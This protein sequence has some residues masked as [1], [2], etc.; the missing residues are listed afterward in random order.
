MF[1][2]GTMLFLSSEVKS[3]TFTINVMNFAFSPANISVSVGDTIK[4][5]YVSG[6]HTTTNNGS[7][8]T[9]RPA[10]A[11][12]WDA[13]INVGMLQY[14][15][16][17]TVPGSYTYKC[18]FHSSMIGNF[19]ATSP[20]INLNLSSIIEGFW[21]GA[22][23][24]SDTVNVTLNKS[25]PPYEILDSAKVK[26]SSSGTGALTFSN[27][28]GGSYFIVVK[29]RNS[30]ETWSK[31]PVVFTS[32]GT[33][34]YDFTSAANKAFGDNLV[35]KDGKYTFYS[36][37]VNQDESINLTDVIQI[38]NEATYFS[39][40]YVV[41]DVNGDN[42]TDLTDVLIAQNNANNFVSVVKP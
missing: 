33:E 1:I 9:S 31:L 19:T 36:G 7:F 13:P 16:V 30:I 5:Q 18:L 23:M 21:N 32:G 17:V 15:Y 26:L 42:I 4:W 38:Y 12:S 22:T 11:P 2:L 35:F 29:H 34:N 41:T 20:V 8:G 27:A 25:A 14:K 6:N 24:V 39:A 3:A 40:G 37:D 28:P 10:G